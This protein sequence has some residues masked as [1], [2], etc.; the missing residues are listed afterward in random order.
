MLSGWLEKWHIQNPTADI[1]WCYDTKLWTVFSKKKKH[2]VER[3]WPRRLVTGGANANKTQESH[4]DFPVRLDV[5]HYISLKTRFEGS[6]HDSNNQY[7]R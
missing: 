1:F 4:T 5:T 3:R 2:P 6:Y 7:A